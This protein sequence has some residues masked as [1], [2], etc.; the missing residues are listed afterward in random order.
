EAAEAINSEDTRKAFAEGFAPNAVV[1]PPVFVVITEFVPVS[2]DPSSK[3]EVEEV[4]ASSGLPV[5]GVT[6]AEW[7]KRVARRKPGQRTAHLKTAF[8]SATMANK[9]IEEGMMVEGRRVY[10][11]KSLPE[12][13]RCFKCQS[14]KGEHMAATCPAL[15]W[16]CAFCA[17]AHSTDKC[18]A[19]PGSAPKCTNCAKAGNQ[20]DHM[21]SDWNCPTTETNRTK[22]QRAHPEAQFRLFPTDDPATWERVDGTNPPQAPPA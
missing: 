15:G 11:R 16:T 7:I 21:A 5:G 12:P 17:G 14:T 9:A 1:K 20:H 6:W 2:F 22:Y 13:P 8:T 4:L 18:D 3:E 19:V 10:S